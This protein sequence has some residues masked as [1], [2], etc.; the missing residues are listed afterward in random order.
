[1]LKY[2]KNIKIYSR[3][4]AAIQDVITVE[5]DFQSRFTLIENL[6]SDFLVCC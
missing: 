5:S 1:M 4:R 3:E 6:I 2:F